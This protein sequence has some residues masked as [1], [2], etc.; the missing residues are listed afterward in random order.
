ME[1]NDARVEALEESIRNTIL[2]IFGP[3]S[4]QYRAHSGFG[5]SHGPLRLGMDRHEARRLAHENF[6][7]G[8]PRAVVTLE[9]LVKGLQENLADFTVD[10][11]TRIRAAF[12]DLDLHP[13]IADAAADLYRDGHYRNAVQ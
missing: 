13:R 9:Q 11:T 5:L 10:A 3:N 7:N 8:L 1:D 6:V 12:N 2:E 4:P